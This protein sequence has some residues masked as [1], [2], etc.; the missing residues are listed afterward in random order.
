MSARL[1][2]IVFC[3]IVF[4]IEPQVHA[5][6][7]D[8]HRAVATLASERLTAHA[9]AR[10]ADL[11]D[12]ASMADVSLWADAVRNTTHPFSYRWHFVNIP[13]TSAGYRKNRD[14]RS[15]PRGDCVIAA[16]TRLETDLEMI[17]TFAEDKQRDTLK[18][19]IHFIGDLHQPLHCGHDNDLGGNRR[20]VREIGG[21]LNLHSAWDSGIIRGSNI[22]EADL[23]TRAN[24]WLGEQDEAAL[25]AG[26]YRTWA[27][28]SFFVARDVAYRQVNG[29]N[30]ISRNERRTA[31]QFITE[32]VAKAGVRLA[33]VLNRTFRE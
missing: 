27:M 21:S 23:V 9:A 19:V 30:R 25:A 5:W 31:A 28:E 6:G 2:S 7:H 26:S 12:G 13:V 22:E 29:D 14:C 24:A 33:A 15:N 11:L 17:S 16:L 32:R 8:A 1:A 3:L 10:V 20:S 4:V 18:F